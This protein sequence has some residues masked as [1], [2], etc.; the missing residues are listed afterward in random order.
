MNTIYFIVFVSIGLL[1][2]VVY[3]Q[4]VNG[5]VSERPNPVRDILESKMDY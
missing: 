5:Q 2:V 3:H 4:V 1:S